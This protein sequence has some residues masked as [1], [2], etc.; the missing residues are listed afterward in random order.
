MIVKG[1]T[2]VFKPNFF[3]Q[4]D[5]ILDYFEKI[6]PAAA[7]SFPIDLDNFLLKKIAPR[8][9]SHAEYPWKRTP[10]RLYRRAIFKQKYYVI[11]KLLPSE[12]QFLAIVYSRRDLSKMPIE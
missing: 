3:S 9:E 5:E 10:Q 12:I 1:R 7:Q 4:L 11:Y 8:P 6:S 2:L